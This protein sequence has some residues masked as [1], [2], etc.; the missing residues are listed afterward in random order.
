MI[1]LRIL[2]SLVVLA[3]GVVI[4]K[5]SVKITENTGRIEFAEKYFKA[6]L[7]GTYTWWKLVGLGI[8]IL[9]VLWLF[10]MVDFLPGS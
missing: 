5:Y 2:G 4:I 9:G 8:M 7:A 1:I 6:P 3:I 10:G